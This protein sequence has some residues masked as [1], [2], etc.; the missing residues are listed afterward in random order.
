MYHPSGLVRSIK[1]MDETTVPLRHYGT[2]GQ[3]GLRY[4]TTPSGIFF[5]PTAGGRAAVENFQNRA[6]RAAKDEAR[7][8]Y[9]PAEAE[10]G[11]PDIPGLAVTANASCTISPVHLEHL[12]S[13]TQP[14]E[15]VNLR[16]RASHRS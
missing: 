16:Q 6:H 4:Y 8:Q 2:M 1:P 5:P 10:A 7:D 11:L 13:T 3:P 14:N 15:I 12:Q 9:G